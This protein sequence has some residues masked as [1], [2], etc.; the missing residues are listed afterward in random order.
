MKIK[1]IQKTKFGL[2]NVKFGMKK[3]KFGT[4]GGLKGNPKPKKITKK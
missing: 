1:K 2:G 3:G 4:K